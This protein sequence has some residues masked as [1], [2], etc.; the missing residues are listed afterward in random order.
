MNLSP[1]WYPNPGSPPVWAPKREGDV[2][3]ADRIPNAEAEKGRVYVEPRNGRRPADS[4]PV[5]GNPKTR[6]SLTGCQWDIN[7]WRRA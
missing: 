3:P 1:P 7:R 4:W 5:L 2:C 6:W